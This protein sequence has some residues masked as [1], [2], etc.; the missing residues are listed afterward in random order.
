MGNITNRERAERKRLAQQRKLER[1]PAKGAGGG[2]RGLPVYGPPVPLGLGWG[3][4][5]AGAGRPKKTDK[6]KLTLVWMDP[7]LAQA[8]ANLPEGARSEY[9]RKALDL[10]VSISPPETFKPEARVTND[11]TPDAISS[12]TRAMS[13]PLSSHTRGIDAMTP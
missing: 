2:G 4:S 5:R 3:G 7:Y 13:P 6:K 12:L 9:I 11:G 8:I 10:M 1:K